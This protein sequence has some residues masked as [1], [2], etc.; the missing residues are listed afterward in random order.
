[1]LASSESVERA[2]QA[3][4]QVVHALE[5]RPQRDVMQAHADHF[6]HALKV[7]DARSTTP[8]LTRDTCALT[9]G[10]LTRATL[11]AGGTRRAAYR[12]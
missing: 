5:G 2:C 4:E 12:D 7:R 10:S 9:Y 8:A 11:N 6:V 1:M 3:A